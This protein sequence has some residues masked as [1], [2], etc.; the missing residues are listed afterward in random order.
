[1]MAVCVGARGGGWRDVKVL[2]LIRTCDNVGLTFL[3]WPCKV[4]S[5]SSREFIYFWLVDVGWV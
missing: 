1:M 4:L 2:A 5:L 3:L